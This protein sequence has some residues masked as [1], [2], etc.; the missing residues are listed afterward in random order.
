MSTAKPAAFIREHHHSGEL[1]WENEGGNCTP[2]FR[3]T[4]LTDAAPDL[5]AA[6][7]AILETSTYDDYPNTV[8]H[9]ALEQGRAAVAKATG[10]AA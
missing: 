10:S 4:A 3:A 2:L 9:K 6:L 1:M 8:E 5:L 7:V